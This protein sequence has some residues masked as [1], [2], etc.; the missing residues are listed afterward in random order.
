M[1][2][3][4]SQTLIKIGSAFFLLASIFVLGQIVLARNG[5]EGF[6]VKDSYIEIQKTDYPQN[7]SL[8]K[9]ENNKEEVAGQVKI[10]DQYLISDLPENEFL[11]EYSDLKSGFQ[12]LS[13]SLEADEPLFDKKN[14]YKPHS[15]FD[16]TKSIFG[17]KV[18]PEYRIEK[19]IN[20]YHSIQ[21]EF[22]LS[23]ISLINHYE[24]LENDSMQVK[25]SLTLANNSE[26]DLNL[27]LL[28]KNQIKANKI[29]WDNQEYF[30]TDN[31][32]KFINPDRISFDTQ[33][34]KAFYDFS[35]IPD[36]FE[37][38]VW[39][40]NKN[41]QNLLILSL[42]VSLFTG[43]TKTIDPTYGVEITILNVHS[44]P[45]VGDNWT[46]SFETI[47]TDDLTI[48]PDDQ[49]T[50]DDLDFI[51]LKCGEEERIPQILV[52]DVIFYS[53]WQCD[54]TGEIIHLV[55]V[56]APH[57]L[58]FLFGDQTA[59]AYNNPDSVTDTFEN[60]DKIASKE[61]LIVIDGDVILKYIWTTCGDP[62]TFIYNGETKIY[63]TVSRNDE[64]WMDRNLGASQVAT[65]WFDSLAY[66][67][68]FQWGRLDDNHQ[69]R[70]SGSTTTTS[71]TD[72]PGHDD[73]IYG[74]GSPYDWRVPQNSNMWEVNG[75]GVNN[76][77]PPGWRIPTYTEWETER[78]SWNSEDATGAYGSTLK[79]P[80]G[81]YRFWETGNISDTTTGHY[82]TNYADDVDGYHISI[83]GA[84]AFMT[85]R[86]RAA[87][88]TVRCIKN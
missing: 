13:I 48:T 69:D 83:S 86:H 35:D 64:C 19:K 76:P 73:F 21:T 81:G 3:S 2:K 28:L 49:V 12:S 38:E 70:A 32:K 33:E 62:I 9:K 11:D 26:N 57:I 61:Y 58:K 65:G 39:V 17:F 14:F 5:N 8:V 66:G 55:N 40:Q 51:S 88:E 20:K 34:G 56:A 24:E 78:A 47:G 37:P 4:K 50:I 44:H 77:C 25:Q 54:G 7:I 15:L 23:Q 22:D 68:L 1:I 80:G 79:F 31:P 72:D 59:F 46:V 63:G 71:G 41:G 75:T 30:L 16:K 87:G 74:M 52:N 27:S 45:Q 60:E 10:V 42:N 18:L 43:E 29:Y 6:T 84:G 82:W 36:E 53:N 67:D 85:Y